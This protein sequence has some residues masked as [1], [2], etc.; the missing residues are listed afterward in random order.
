MA[1]GSDGEHSF[2]L[3]PRA[4][5]LLVE[6]QTRIATRYSERAAPADAGRGARHPRGT[7]ANRRRCD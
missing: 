3:T 1:I 2:I 7:T 6:D 4:K 5:A